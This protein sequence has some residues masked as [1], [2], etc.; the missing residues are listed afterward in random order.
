MSA[1]ITAAGPVQALT[2][3]AGQPVR[4]ANFV[5]RIISGWLLQERRIASRRQIMDYHVPGELIIVDTPPVGS[6]NPDSSWFAKTALAILPVSPSDFEVASALARRTAILNE[7]VCSLGCRDS[8]ERM[9][10]TV[11]EMLV[12]L[13]ELHPGDFEIPLSQDDWAALLGISTIHVNRTFRVLREQGLAFNHS[14]GHIRIPDPT[15]LATVGGFD[16]RYLE[17]W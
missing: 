3:R 9:A 13:G 15:A 11:C 1:A 5:G 17:R 10:H 7:R 2:Y 16:A 14:R 12:R 4:G 8:R 6:K